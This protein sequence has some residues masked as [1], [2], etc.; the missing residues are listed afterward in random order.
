MPESSNVVVI[1]RSPAMNPVAPRGR[2]PGLS[3]R[4]AAQAYGLRKAS[5]APETGSVSGKSG[6]SFDDARIPLGKNADVLSAATQQRSSENI[7]R[8]RRSTT[9]TERLLE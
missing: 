4:A 8:Q 7:T 6:W 3:F 5:W 1:V 2:D 9:G